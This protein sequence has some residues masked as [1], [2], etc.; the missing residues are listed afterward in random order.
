[1]MNDHN[2]ATVRPGASKNYER[3]TGTW[4]PAGT[5]PAGLSRT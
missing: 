4:G 3:Q 2:R 5:M 1:M